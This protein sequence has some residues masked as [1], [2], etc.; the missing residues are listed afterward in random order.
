VPREDAP[1]EWVDLTEGDGLKAARSFEAEREA[2]DTAKEVEHAQH[3]CNHTRQRPGTPN[4][5]SRTMQRGAG[6]VNAIDMSRRMVID[7]PS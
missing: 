3:H 2:A 7:E 1:A 4:T 6:G 5:I